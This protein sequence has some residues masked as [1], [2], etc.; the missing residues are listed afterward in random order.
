[1]LT[2]SSTGR[3]GCAQR[4]Q[5][6]CADCFH[7]EKKSAIAWE[8]HDIGRWVVPNS[9]SIAGEQQASASCPLP[10]L[11][12]PW[13]IS[14]DC[15]LHPVPRPFGL[16]TRRMGLSERDRRAARNQCYNERLANQRGG[17]RDLGEK[18]QPHAGPQLQHNPI[19]VSLAW[20]APSA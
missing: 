6:G 11:C 2:P 17:I 18:A 15:L 20:R 3:G 4:G 14:P 5:D 7:G 13:R 12:T 1:M 9:R 10:P 19:F 16:S 8:I